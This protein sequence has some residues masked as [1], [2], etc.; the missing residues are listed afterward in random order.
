MVELP[1]FRSGGAKLVVMM[2]TDC[3]IRSEN[4]VSFFVG[5]GVPPAS[6]DDQ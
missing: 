5:D 4:Q 2:H 3:L 1:V 6:I